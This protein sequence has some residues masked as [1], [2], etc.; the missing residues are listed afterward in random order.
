ML[1]ITEFNKNKNSRDGYQDKCRK[2]FSDYNRKRYASNREKFKAD[3][4]RYREENP[5]RCLM[6]RLK[7]CA[8]NP[9][10]YN[11]NKA[12]EAALKAGVIKNPQVCAGCG[13][14]PPEHRIEA[15]HH[16]YSDPLNVVWLCTPCHREMD[17]R[18]RLHEQAM[19]SGSVS[20]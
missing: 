8:K 4:R 1:P 14:K 7:A 19:G 9:T 5:E 12:V 18:R 15:H 2:C 3:V 10:H 16:D 11:A 17:K 13:C 6:T 20:D